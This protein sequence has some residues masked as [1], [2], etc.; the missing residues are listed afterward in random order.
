M[1]SQKQVNVLRRGIRNGYKGSSTPGPHALCDKHRRM[2][3]ESLYCI[4]CVES[5]L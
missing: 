3:T 5:A 2:Y 4:D 1:F